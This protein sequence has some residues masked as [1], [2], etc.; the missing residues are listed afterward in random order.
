MWHLV[1]CHHSDCQEW[2]KSLKT[3]GVNIIKNTAINYHVNFNPNFSRV[4]IPQYFIAIPEYFIAILGKIMIYNI[5]YTN[6][7]V[8]YCPSTVIAMIIQL[9]NTS[10]WYYYEMA[11]NY[12]SKKLYNIRPS[13]RFHLHLTFNFF[14][15][16]FSSIKLIFHQ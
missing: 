10:W 1:V 4:T 9:Y 7:I 14:T 11:V 2:I 6:T 3:P 13:D 16:N 5:G 15:Q 8:I 12:C